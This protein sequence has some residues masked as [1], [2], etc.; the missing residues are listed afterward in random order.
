MR[1]LVITRE[2]P[3]HVLGGISY[4]LAYLYSQICELGYEVT[5][6]S[7]VAKESKRSAME[8]IHNDIEVQTVPY[9]SIQGNHLKFPLLLKMYISN[10]FINQ[11]DIAFTH[12]PL[13]Y[14]LP[15]PTVGK[16]HD[17]PREERQFFVE[18]LTGAWR[19]VDQMIDPTRRWV[20]KRSLRAVDHAIFNSHL[21]RKSWKK[22]YDIDISSNI[23]YNGVDTETFY[24]QEVQVKEEYLLFVG[25]SE[26]KGLSSIL[27]Y[28]EQ[29]SET[30]YI[31]GDLDT[32]LPENVHCLGHINQDRL[33]DLYS[34]ALATIHPAGFE[35][36][37]NVI[38]ESIACG[39]PV[40]TTHR[41]GASELVSEE[42][43]YIGKSI[44]QGV[45]HCRQLGG[46][47]STKIASEYTWK[48]VAE[49]SIGIVMDRFDTT[50]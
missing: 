15:I 32:E 7:G 26:R 6:V 38:I 25:D 34:G 14:E 16:Y 12:T 45:S 42:C 2:F 28:A 18:D 4:H 22:H 9:G 3:P 31:A 10:E 8:Q 5:V 1:I 37:G 33:A 21:C 41:C 43:G 40:V 30:I 35:A 20:E 13:P 36:F 24:P 39:T 29:S 19:V 23:I 11:Y 50:V 46:K 49:R 47:C 17:C 48:R 27:A 44:S